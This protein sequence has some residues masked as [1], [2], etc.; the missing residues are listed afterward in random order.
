M[1]EDLEDLDLKRCNLTSFHFDL[2]SLK[3]LDLSHN[4]IHFFS[5]KMPKL[6]HLLLNNN[7]INISEI[8]IK[9][10][11]NL[12]RINHKPVEEYYE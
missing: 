6:E 9:N 5:G 7:P 1:H 10:Y 4:N 2:P 11:P 8:K 12:K 3:K